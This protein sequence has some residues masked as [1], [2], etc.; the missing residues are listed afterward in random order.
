MS[1]VTKQEIHEALCKGSDQ[2]KMRL[3]VACQVNGISVESLE[4]LIANVVNHAQVAI[5]P[6]LKDYEYLRGGVNNGKF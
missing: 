2:E 4:E 5:E 1:G 6:A 3:A